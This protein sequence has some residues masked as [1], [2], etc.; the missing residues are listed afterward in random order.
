MGQW[1]GEVNWHGSRSQ[2]PTYGGQ[3]ASFGAGQWD[4]GAASTGSFQQAAFGGVGGGAQQSVI[5]SASWGLGLLKQIASERTSMLINLGD[6][7]LPQEIYRSILE[8]LVR[9]AQIEMAQAPLSFG[10]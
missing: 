9:E 4:G 7:R 2:F 5:G 3:G 6:K 10:R 1:P 8:M